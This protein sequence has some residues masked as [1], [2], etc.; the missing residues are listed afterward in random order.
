MLGGL[1]ELQLESSVVSHA[2]V[3]EQ[4]RAHHGIRDSHGLE[5]FFA[6]QARS[7]RCQERVG[8]RR[9]INLSDTS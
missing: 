1:I 7:L 6:H 5:A 2:T 4:P 9:L 8:S 3:S